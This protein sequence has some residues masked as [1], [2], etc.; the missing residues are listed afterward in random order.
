MVL[1]YGEYR[2]ARACGHGNGD[3]SGILCSDETLEC[4]AQRAREMH[5]IEN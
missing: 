4:N 2:T 1:V 5:L 3:Y